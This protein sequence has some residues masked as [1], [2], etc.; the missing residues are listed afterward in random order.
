MSLILKAAH[1]ASKMHKGQTREVTGDPYD[2][3]LGRVAARV[4]QFT[5][6]DYGVEADEELVAAAWLHDVLEDTPVTH[7][8]LVRQ[9]GSKV[10]DVVR[11]LT[12]AFTKKSAPAMN[13]AARKQAELERLYKERIEVRAIKLV[14][15]MDNL[16]EL[17]P[18]SDFAVVYERESADLLRIGNR[19]L[20]RLTEEL[21]SEI[22]HLQRRISDARKTRK[23]EDKDLVAILEDVQDQ[24]HPDCWSVCGQDEVMSMVRELQA[25]RAA[26]RRIDS[27]LSRLGASAYVPVMHED[28][29]YRAH[30]DVVK[31]VR[32]AIADDAEFESFWR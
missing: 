19:D 5:R 30:H 23:V 29:G 8:E 27:A 2:R 32:A 21:A 13:R 31:V 26:R 17:D 25:H 11:G 20:V 22:L 10:A 7:E 3:H 9:F 6:E 1:F 24:S 28:G 14:D 15:R 4:S 16:R 18:S 12:N